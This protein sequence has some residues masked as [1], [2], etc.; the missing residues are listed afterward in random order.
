MEMEV[1]PTTESIS[2]S[3]SHGVVMMNDVAT[4]IVYIQKVSCWGQCPVQAPC[5]GHYVWCA[6]MHVCM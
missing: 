3:L 6:H 4:F 5:A 1:D 2:L